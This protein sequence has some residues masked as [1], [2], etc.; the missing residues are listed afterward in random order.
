MGVGLNVRQSRFPGPEMIPLV[1]A[2]LG[3]LDS[4]LHQPRS[5]TPG[6]DFYSFGRSLDQGPHGA[7]VR[8]KDPFGAVIGMAD[9][10]ADEALF[11]TDFTRIGHRNCSR[12]LSSQR[13]MFDD[14]C[15]HR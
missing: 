6:T 12:T 1:N 3:W 7:K 9:I 13:K 2:G 15:Y 4:L 8:A 10:V 11:S 14:V 5:Q